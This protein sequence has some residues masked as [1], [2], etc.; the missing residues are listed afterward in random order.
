MAGTEGREPATDSVVSLAFKP[1]SVGKWRPREVMAMGSGAGC[2]AAEARLGL[3]SQLPLGASCKLL[4]L[5]VRLGT[6]PYLSSASPAI[7]ASLC[8]YVVCVCVKKKVE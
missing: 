3:D 7:A 1:A 6:I 8:V 2:W 4:S 5:N